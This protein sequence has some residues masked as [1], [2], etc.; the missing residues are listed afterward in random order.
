M[1]PPTTL[2]LYQGTQSEDVSIWKQH[3]SR[4]SFSLVCARSDK[5]KILSNSIYCNFDE[6]A[7]WYHKL[8]CAAP[9]ERAIRTTEARLLSRDQTGNKSP[10]IRILENK[11]S[12][13]EMCHAKNFVYWTLW[14]LFRAR[15]SI[16]RTLDL[17][18]P[19]HKEK[20]VK[21]VTACFLCSQGGHDAHLGHQTWHWGSCDPMGAHTRMLPNI[22]GCAACFSHMTGELGRFTFTRCPNLLD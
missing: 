20:E 14:S 4:N 18:P 12:I 10:K 22:S 8:A 17:F 15:N 21:W 2:G 6:L 3:F 16:Q 9:C 11:F 13:S 19:K 1:A 5:K 7:S